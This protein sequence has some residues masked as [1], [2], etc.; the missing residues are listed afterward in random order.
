MA[1]TVRV[2]SLVLVMHILGWLPDKAVRVP[3]ATN[4]FW[5]PDLPM[6]QFAPA[7]NVTVPEVMVAELL[8]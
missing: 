2:V 5:P 3:A 7:D 6:S 4:K 1:P 8:P